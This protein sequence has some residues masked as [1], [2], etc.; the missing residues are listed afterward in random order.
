M[1]RK[2]FPAGQCAAPRRLLE[3]APP[4]QP[5]RKQIATPFPLPALL[6]AL[7]QSPKKR[8]VRT[9]A[10]RPC[11]GGTVSP[12]R[13]MFPYSPWQTLTG[14]DVSLQHL[15]LQPCPKSLRE[16]SPCYPAPFQLLAFLCVHVGDNTVPHLQ[17]PKSTLE[18]LKYHERCLL[19]AGIGRRASGGAVFVFACLG[20]WQTQG[21][22]A[23]CVWKI[24]ASRRGPRA[25]RSLPGSYCVVF[26]A[27]QHTTPTAPHTPPPPSLLSQG[28]ETRIKDRVCHQTLD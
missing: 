1:L 20:K 3:T 21:A 18:Q 7:F 23:C 8:T 26:G 15:Y 10:S 16:S 19:L 27:A 4:G 14:Q 5:G 11:P 9:W 22:S 17:K 13:A 6:W 12:I 25:K 24:P 28:F 2:H